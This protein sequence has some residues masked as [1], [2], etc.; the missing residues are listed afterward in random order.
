MRISGC[1]FIISI[2]WYYVITY[3]HWNDDPSGVPPQ[4][5]VAFPIYQFTFFRHPQLISVNPV[6]GDSTG[7]ATIVKISGSGFFG[8]GAAANTQNMVS[9]IMKGSTSRAIVLSDSEIECEVSCSSSV[10]AGFVGI[11]Q[12]SLNGGMDFTPED[13]SPIFVCPAL[14]TIMGVKP[15]FGTEK[16]GTPLLISVRGIGDW[17]VA[18][19]SIDMGGPMLACSFSSPGNICVTT[20]T[21]AWLTA[22][23][24]LSEGVVRCHTPPGV[25]GT[26]LN[27]QLVLSQDGEFN[28]G[29]VAMALGIAEFSFVSS[30][31]LSSVVSQSPLVIEGSGF[32]ETSSSSSFSCIINGTLT[33]TDVLSPTSIHYG[34]P[35]G[36]LGGPAVV[37][38]SSNGVDVEGELVTTGLP[39]APIL[40]TIIP[41]RG[42]IGGGTR[43]Q[44]L[45]SISNAA[46][47]NNSAD[48]MFQSEDGTTTLV[49]CKFGHSEVNVSAFHVV[50]DVS[51]SQSVR[52][53]S[54][55]C[56]LETNIPL[57]IDSICVSPS[58]LNITS[59][60]SEC[61]YP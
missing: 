36:W 43:I 29:I 45:A 59:L 57:L 25:P 35:P 53:S 23:A 46:G 8:G 2:R 12:V 24:H 31:V 34:L 40:W 41:S 20:T 55:H 14:P 15:L 48:G 10:T 21:T 19:S 39:P 33:Y 44:V 16:G 56:R 18:A 11:L 4:G 9:C 28:G 42:V 5:G 32:G 61:I 3:A 17:I 7:R 6:V 30:A 47:A 13:K 22:A 52:Q 58:N 50:S 27:V 1:C 54:P 49:R 37:S 26:S 38:V 60:T 51:N